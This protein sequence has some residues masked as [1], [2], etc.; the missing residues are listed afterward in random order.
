M[1][2]Q[3]TY[4]NQCTREPPLH[5]LTFYIWLQKSY[6]VATQRNP[7]Y[8][9]TTM[10]TQNTCLS[11]C[12]RKHPLTV[13]T[14]PICRQKSHAVGTQKNHHGETIPMSSQDTCLNRHTRHN[15][16]LTY[17]IVQTSAF[18]PFSKSPLL[19]ITQKSHAVGTKRTLLEE[20]APRGPKRHMLKNISKLYAGKF[21]D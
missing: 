5:V 7:L 11:K 16:L 12:T 3:K 20:T 2:S 6:V 17:G 21:C 13:L 15:L 1:S 8:E 10:S 4:L 19:S 14:L 18:K 9:T